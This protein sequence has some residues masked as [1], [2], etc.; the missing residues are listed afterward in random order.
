MET[1]SRYIAE[2]RNELYIIKNQ[3]SQS[4]EHIKSTARME[5][6]IKKSIEEHV[7]AMERRNNQKIENLMINK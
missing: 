2:L 1:Q 5:E 3:N 4:F 7:M 6:T